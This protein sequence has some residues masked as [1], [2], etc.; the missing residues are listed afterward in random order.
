MERTMCER[1]MIKRGSVVRDARLRAGKTQKEI[2]CK[3][4]VSARHIMYIENG[5]QKPGNDLLI[6]LIREL[7]IPADLLFYPDEIHCHVKFAQAVNLLRKCGNK[8]LDAVISMLGPLLAE[9]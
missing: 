3:L 6:R 1:L 9:T 5:R 8:E 2:A 4:Q 7:S